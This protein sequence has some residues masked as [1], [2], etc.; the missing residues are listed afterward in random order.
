MTPLSFTY[1]FK[2]PSP[3]K[4]TLR[5]RPSRYEVWRE[6]NSIPNSMFERCEMKDIARSERAR[7]GQEER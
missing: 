6:H 1:L 2:G 5:V 3:N 7:E 4:V